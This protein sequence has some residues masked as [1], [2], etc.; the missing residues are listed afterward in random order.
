MGIYLHASARLLPVCLSCLNQRLGS[1]TSALSP[2]Y[3]G[4]HYTNVWQLVTFTAGRVSDCHSK[5]RAH[6]NTHK[7]THGLAGKAQ[8]F[9]SSTGY[10]YLN[11]EYLCASVWGKRFRQPPCC[12]CSVSKFAVIFY[13]YFFLRREYVHHYVH[14]WKTVENKN[15]QNTK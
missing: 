12:C 3:K 1:A 11:S 9:W 13:F 5:R 2:P 14:H 10:Y 15:K 4:M 8:S 7:P 6:I